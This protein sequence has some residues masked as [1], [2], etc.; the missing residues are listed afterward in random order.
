MVRY[1][2][3]RVGQDECTIG[4]GGGDGRRGEVIVCFCPVFHFWKILKLY[5]PSL[6]EINISRRPFLK[7]GGR[8]G[9]TEGEGR[10]REDRISTRRWI[11]MTWYAFRASF[12]FNTLE[13]CNKFL[14]ILFGFYLSPAYVQGRVNVLTSFCV[15]HLGPSVSRYVDFSSV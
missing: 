11:L 3:E 7:N 12:I 1:V 4:G 13:S 9:W 14:F 8:K 5:N 15:I 10:G 6:V 2:Q